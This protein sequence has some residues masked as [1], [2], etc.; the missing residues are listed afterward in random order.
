MSGWNSLLDPQP[1][2]NTQEEIDAFNEAANQGPTV[3]EQLSE[4]QR[5]VVALRADVARLQAD[6]QTRDTRVFAAGVAEGERL[7]VAWMRVQSS[8]ALDDVD[9]VA[10]L[11]RNGAHRGTSV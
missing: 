9:T 5:A 6:I 4:A 7:V 2:G 10:E 3:E 1:A 11:L 8:C